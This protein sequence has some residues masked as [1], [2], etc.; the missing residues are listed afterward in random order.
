MVQYV[1]PSLAACKRK[2][3]TCCAAGRLHSRRPYFDP[4]TIRPGITESFIGRR[5]YLTVIARNASDEAIRLSFF[6]AMDCFASL[7]MTEFEWRA[8]HLRRHR[9]RKRAIQYSE[10]PEIES[11]SCSVLDPPLS[12]RMTIPDLADASVALL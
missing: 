3:S 7:A 11:R 4:D 8:Q 1:T 10:T 6:C 2:P 12:R 9:P 5:V